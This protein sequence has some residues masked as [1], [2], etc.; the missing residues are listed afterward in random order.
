[1]M[2]CGDLAIT[3]QLIGDAIANSVSPGFV[4]G[5]SGNVVEGWLKNNEVFSNRVGLP[6]GLNNG[7]L[8][9]VWCGTQN[10]NTYDIEIY[11]HE[12]DEVNLTLLVTLQIT[13]ATRTKI[14]TQADIKTANGGN[15]VS[16]GTLKQLGVKIKNG[17]ANEPKVSLFVGGTP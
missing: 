8:L 15:D 1:M 17:P 12:G 10:L 11:E 9:S 7:L 5:R 16:V 3:E 13:V 14:F 2:K 4:Y 6:F